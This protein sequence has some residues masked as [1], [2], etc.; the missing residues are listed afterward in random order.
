MLDGVPSRRL[1]SHYRIIGIFSFSVAHSIH[2]CVSS[3]RVLL[4]FFSHYFHKYLCGSATRRTNS[5]IHLNVINYYNQINVLM[6]DL[7]LVLLNIISFLVFRAFYLSYKIY[8]W[9]MGFFFKERFEEKVLFQLQ[10]NLSY[11]FPQN[12]AR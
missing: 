4:L 11:I 12:I 6:K 1:L 10:F 5:L 7:F 3:R 8:S 2:T 9:Y